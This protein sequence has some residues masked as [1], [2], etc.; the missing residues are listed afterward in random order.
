MRKATSLN[1]KPSAISFVLFLTMEP[2]IPA[3]A[4]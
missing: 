2:S 3:A 1:A 4:L